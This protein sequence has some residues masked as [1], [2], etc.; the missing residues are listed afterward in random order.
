MTRPDS[1]Y[2]FTRQS[3]ARMKIC[4]WLSVLAGGATFLLVAFFGLGADPAG[5]FA[6]FA[7]LI[8][9]FLSFGLLSRIEKGLEKDD[10]RGCSA[11][12]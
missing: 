11:D 4:I 2:G 7:A 10:S 9:N 12:G 6:T 3:W 1:L 8:A 5:G